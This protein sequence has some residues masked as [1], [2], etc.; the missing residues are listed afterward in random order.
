MEWLWEIIIV[1]VGEGYGGCVEG[2]SCGYCLLLGWIVAGG[3][4]A[5]HD[6]VGR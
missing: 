3:G 4:L 2:V 1:V 6:G 5:A